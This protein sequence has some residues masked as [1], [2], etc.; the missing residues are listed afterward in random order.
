[1]NTTLTEQIKEKELRL[2]REKLKMI[3][4]EKKCDEIRKHNNE[5]YEKELL[6]KKQERIKNARMEMENTQRQN[7]IKKSLEQ[8]TKEKEKQ[9]ILNNQRKMQ[10]IDF[11]KKSER[12]EQMKALA[13]T[14]KRQIA[15]KLHESKKARESEIKEYQRMC[16]KNVNPLLNLCPHGKRY[17][18]AHC[19]KN[20]PRS[21]ISK[22]PLKH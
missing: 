14:L 16:T 12:I 6:R 4:I 3:E 8:N 15:D 22:R 18:C 1:M 2:L 13:D 10:N 21:F 20:Y 5:K 7:N 9:I 11:Q 19:N 17:V